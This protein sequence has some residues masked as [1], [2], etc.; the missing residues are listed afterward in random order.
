MI[1]TQALRDRASDIHIEP[2]TERVRVRYRID[3]ALHDVLELPAVDGPGRGRAASRSWPD[4]NIV[5]RRRA[6]D[7]QISMEIDG[8]ASTSGSPPPA[9]SRARR[10]CCGC[11]TR[12]ASCSGSTSSACPTT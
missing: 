11:S 10:S 2:Q 4:M 6:Q 1:I 8:R 12:A 3:G 9:S 7:G 5:E